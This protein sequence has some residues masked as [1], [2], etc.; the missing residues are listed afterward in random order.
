MIGFPDGKHTDNPDWTLKEVG[1]SLVNNLKF[2]AN[3][4][5]TYDDSFRQGGAKV[6]WFVNARLPQRFRTTRGQALQLQGLNDNTVPIALTD[7]LHIAFG[8]KLRR[9]RR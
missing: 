8:W 3:V 7:Q 4:S 9:K 6:G 5:R 1:R 2:A